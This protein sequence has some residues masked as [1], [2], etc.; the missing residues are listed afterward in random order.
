LEEGELERIVAF[1]LAKGNM[2]TLEDG[3]FLERA[4]KSWILS[5]TFA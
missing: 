1:S 2:F 5:L 4:K 3:R